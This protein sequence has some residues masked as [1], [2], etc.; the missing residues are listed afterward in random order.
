MHKGFWYF[1]TGCTQAVT[2]C[3]SS[4]SRKLAQR[5][6]FHEVTLASTD[7]TCLRT[8]PMTSLL[9]SWHLLLRKQ[10]DLDRSSRHLHFVDSVV[11]A[12]GTV[13]NTA[14]SVLYSSDARIAVL[15]LGIFCCD[16][17]V[18][19][20]QMILVMVKTA[21][22]VL[23]VFLLVIYYL[24]LISNICPSGRCLQVIYTWS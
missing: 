19:S 1:F 21:L 23:S 7:L 11:C 9:R 24:L 22:V 10:K 6:G 17:K 8:A 16:W 5:R 18:I 2:A 12:D 4:A 15:T 13:G 14:T 20:N 3:S